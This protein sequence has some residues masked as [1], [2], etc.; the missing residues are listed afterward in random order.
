MDKF[1]LLFIENVGNLVCPAEFEIG[2]NAKV[3]LLSTPEGADKPAKYPLMFAES[4]VL[5]INKMDLAPY[6]DFDLDKARRDARKINPELEIFEISCK[7][8][9]G[10]EVWYDWLR[11]EIAKVKEG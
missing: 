6:V 1:D 7:S 2:E 3:M 4:K 9:S 10:L 11:Q 8:G 5:L